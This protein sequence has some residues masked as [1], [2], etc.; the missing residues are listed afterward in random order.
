[1]FTRF[2]TVYVQRST[3]VVVSLFLLRSSH[4][5]VLGSAAN[6]PSTLY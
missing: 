5:K 2:G 1:M 3:L 6:T 4:T